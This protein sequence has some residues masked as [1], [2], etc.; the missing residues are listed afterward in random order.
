MGKDLDFGGFNMDD[1][2][3]DIQLDEMTFNSFDNMFEVQEEPKEHR[4][5]FIVICT[6]EEQ[7]ELIREKFNLGLK[8]KS[9]RGKYE[10]N[11]IQAEQLIDLF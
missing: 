2:N 6:T 5:H 8:T 4:S 11:I 10:T 3:L 9:G 7:D 1:L